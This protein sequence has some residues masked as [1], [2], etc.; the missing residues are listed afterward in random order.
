MLFFTE[1]SG[2]LVMPVRNWFRLVTGLWCCL[3]L[4]KHEHACA[5]PGSQKVIC[6]TFQGS[7]VL[8]RAVLTDLRCCFHC[9]NICA[10]ADAAA[11]RISGN[12]SHSECSMATSAHVSFTAHTRP[13]KR[14]LWP[15]S[16]SYWLYEVSV[17]N[18]LSFLV[19]CD[20]EWKSA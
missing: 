13:V 8:P 6:R 9:V 2:K 18:Y 19:C 15:N 5:G 7:G 4:G 20:S 1:C 16:K 11:G 14:G 3:K 17:L 12:F 10:D